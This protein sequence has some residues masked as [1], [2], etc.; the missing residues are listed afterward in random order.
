MLQD[1]NPTVCDAA[2]NS[3]FI[4]NDIN[5]DL[6]ILSVQAMPFDTL[7]ANA[8]AKTQGVQVNNLLV[9]FIGSKH[10]LKQAHDTTAITTYREKMQ[11]LCLKDRKLIKETER[12]KEREKKLQD[13][14][15]WWENEQERKKEGQKMFSICYYRT[16]KG[17]RD[18]EKQSKAKTEGICTYSI[19]TEQFT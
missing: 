17:W 10:P 15:G 6:E 2:I 1:S 13:E 5:T 14:M 12:S 4:S 9:Q 11:V 3:Y 16:C 7:W 8:V 18:A 19:T